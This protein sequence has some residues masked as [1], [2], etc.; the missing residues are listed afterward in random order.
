MID[1]ILFK[2]GY[3]PQSKLREC[4]VDY[5]EVVRK[6][7]NEKL[8][9]QAQIATFKPKEIFD[10]SIGDPTPTDSEE[11]RM[12]VAQV[13]GFFKEILEPKLKQMISSA[14][15]I[16]E[17]TSSDRDSDLQLKG[18]IYSFREMIKWGNSVLNEQIANQTDGIS[19]VE[20]NTLKDKLN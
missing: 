16:L 10:I 2:F 20:I 11:R 14:H 1:K 8:A 13:A 17:A 9:L 19:E 6:M 3:V 18:V 7:T 12:Y 15:N 5:S 4:V